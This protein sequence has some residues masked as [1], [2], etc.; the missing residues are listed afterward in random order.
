MEKKGLVCK[1]ISLNIE[2]EKERVWEEKEKI[3]FSVEE[4]KE[5]KGG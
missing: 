5:I 1:I 3:R 4:K 2:I